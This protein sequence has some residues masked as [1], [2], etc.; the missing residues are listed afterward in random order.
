VF[1]STLRLGKLVCKSMSRG[2][3]IM[4]FGAPVYCVAA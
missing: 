1:S 2:P 4:V 3:Q